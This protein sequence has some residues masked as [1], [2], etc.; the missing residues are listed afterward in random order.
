MA[1][2]IAKNR[3]TPTETSSTSSLEKKE[4]KAEVTSINEPELAVTK[5]EKRFF[6]QR[7]K[8]KDFLNYGM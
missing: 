2:V 7:T 3:R 8:V 1:T 5:L 6:F 4:A